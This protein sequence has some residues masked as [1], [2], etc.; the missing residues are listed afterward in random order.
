MTTDPRLKRLR[1]LVVRV[2][3]M[4]PSPERDRILREI[5][6]R[7][8]DVDTGVMPRAMLPVDPSPPA[9][10][11]GP[12]RLRKAPAEPKPVQ[13]PE[14]AKAAPVASPGDAPAR[15]GF[16]LKS[17]SAAP[18]MPLESVLALADELLSLDDG[19]GHSPSSDGQAPADHGARPWTKG[20]RG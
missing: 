20:L 16:Q 10:W 7:A 2:E 12:V 17:T 11:T 19:P 14:P 18:A 6:A 9:R 5:R 13:P 15:V 8:V 3:L 1:D 4:P